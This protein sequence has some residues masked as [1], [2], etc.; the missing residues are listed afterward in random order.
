MIA[1][2]NPDKLYDAGYF[3][4]ALCSEFLEQFGEKPRASFLCFA[5]DG[6]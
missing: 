1:K 3:L 5:T 4:G 6:A 2:C